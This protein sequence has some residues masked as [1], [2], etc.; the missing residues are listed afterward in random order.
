MAEEEGAC[1]VIL[2]LIIW[3]AVVNGMPL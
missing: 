3:A 2:L 1:R